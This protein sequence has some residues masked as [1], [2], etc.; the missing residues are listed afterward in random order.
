MTRARFLGGPFDGRIYSIP[1]DALQWRIAKPD[2]FPGWLPFPSPVRTLVEGTYVKWD[3]F[4]DE[5][6]LPLFMWTG[7]VPCVRVLPDERR[8]QAGEPPRGGEERDG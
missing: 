6:G 7:A 3:G 8:T 2:G 5:H 1:L 4:S